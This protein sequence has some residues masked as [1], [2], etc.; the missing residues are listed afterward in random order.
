MRIIASVSLIS[1]LTAASAN[2]ALTHRY[3]FDTDAS[4]S[5]GSAHGTIFNG[6]TAGGGVLNF[7]NPAFPGASVPRGYMEIPTSAVPGTGSMTIEQW[8]TFGGSGFYTEAWTLTDHA[9]GANPPGAS[10]G[11][12]LMHT[13][14][15]PQGGPNPSAGGSS[16]AQTLAGYGGGAESR[17]YSTTPG[18]GFAGGGYLDD[19][20]TY[21]ATT[22]IDGIAGTLSYYIDGVHQST[23]PAI[24]LGSYSFTNMYLGR[25]PFAGDN[26]VSGTVDEFRVYSEARNAITIAGDF[27]A[28][29][30]QLVPE[31]TSLALIGMG[32]LVLRRR[33]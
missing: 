4:D 3:S 9:G 17:A 7:N 30:N 29:P 15:N 11:Q 27:A 33:R 14:S 26:Y 23:I 21:M 8:F 25:S 24:S 2:A 1:F 18:F 16:L 31:P 20:R 6:A 13:V 19:G 5:V 12:Y 22:V 10:S 28:G 32:S